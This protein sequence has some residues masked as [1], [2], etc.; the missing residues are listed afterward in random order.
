[1]PTYI[2]IYVKY[3]CEFEVVNLWTEMWFCDVSCDV[4]N[5]CIV[6]L[7]HIYSELHWYNCCCVLWT[8]CV[9]VCNKMIYWFWKPT[10]NVRSSCVM[11]GI[12]HVLRLRY[13]RI[14]LC[15]VGLGNRRPMEDLSCV[16]MGIFH[17]WRISFLCDDGR[18]G[19]ISGTK[20]LAGWLVT[21]WLEL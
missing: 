4:M 16:M 3:I 13:V 11:I 18:I 19:N 7:W 10:S 6:S 14:E 8:T 12:L 21:I 9:R 1:M 5:M 15:E 17:A 2:Y 20:P